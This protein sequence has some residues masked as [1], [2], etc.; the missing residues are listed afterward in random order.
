[1][2]DPLSWRTLCLFWRETKQRSSSS[3]GRP[4]KMSIGIPSSF[5][6]ISRRMHVSFSLQIH[7]GM[8]SVT[9]YLSC[10]WVNPSPY[11]SFVLCSFFSHSL[12]CISCSHEEMCDNPIGTTRWFTGQD[13]N[14]LKN[15]MYSGGWGGIVTIH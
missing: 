1:M 4:V 12:D 8:Q 15:L 14:G 11:C 10:T 13:W 3:E 6:E 9:T 7:K 2:G 5:V